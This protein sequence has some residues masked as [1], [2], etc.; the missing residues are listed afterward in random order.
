MEKTKL[1]SERQIL[2]HLLMCE[3]VRV[4]AAVMGNWG[5]EETV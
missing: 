4:Q 2:G 5:A 1:E 3:R